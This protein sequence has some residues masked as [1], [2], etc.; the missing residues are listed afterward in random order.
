MDEDGVVSVVDALVCSVAAAEKK[1]AGC[2]RDSMYSR[3][4]FLRSFSLDVSSCDVDARS[5][6]LPCPADFAADDGDDGDDDDDEDVVEFPFG[7]D[8]FV[9]DCVN[10]LDV[11]S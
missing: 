3:N 2:R 11:D 8:S 1:R 10:R 6:A 4:T 7:P 9:V 5:P